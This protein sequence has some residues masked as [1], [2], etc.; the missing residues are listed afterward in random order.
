M[1]SVNM[2]LRLASYIVFAQILSGCFGSSGSELKEPLDIDLKKE[3][4]QG[5]EK[6]PENLTIPADARIDWQKF[7][8]PGPDAQQRSLLEQDLAT[9]K[10][11]DDVNSLLKKGR[12]ELALGRY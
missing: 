12:N 8:K 4:V 1:E 11:A 2:R 6:K 7:F 3:P 10:D 5:E 9:A